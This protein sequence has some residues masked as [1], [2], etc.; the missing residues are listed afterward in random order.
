MY[1]KTAP[2]SVGHEKLKL[3]CPSTPCAQSV[4]IIY[5]PN[6]MQIGLGL[7]FHRAMG[8]IIDTF[9]F[10]EQRRRMPTYL[11]HKKWCYELRRRTTYTS[12]LCV[13]EIFWKAHH[14]TFFSKAKQQKGGTLA[15]SDN[16]APPNISTLK[17]CGGGGTAPRAPQSRFWVNAL[18]RVSR[19]RQPEEEAGRHLDKSVWVTF[20]TAKSFTN[21]RATWTCA[22]CAKKRNIQLFSNAQLE[23]PLQHKTR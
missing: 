12:V 22:V 10:P 8:L 21:K 13:Y 5:D 9:V 6:Q 15:S 20:G 23:T 19:T 17:H 16:A 3:E 7:L 2:G 4:Q 11:P 14:T 1:D 18:K